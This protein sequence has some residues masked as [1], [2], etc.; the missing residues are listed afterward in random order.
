MEDQI[1]V[2]TVENDETPEVEEIESENSHDEE[3]IEEIDES[4]SE[5]SE[6][7]SDESDEDEEPKVKK[8]NGFKKRIDKLKH[9]EALAKEEADYWKQKALEKEEVKKEPSNTVKTNDAPDPDDFETYEDFVDALTDYKVEQKLAARSEAKSKETQQSKA[10]EQAKVWSEKVNSFSEQTP[11]F[12]EVMEDA[13]DFRISEAAKEALTFSESGPELMYLLA[14]NPEELERINSLPPAM[15][16]M[17]L[18]R[19]EAGLSKKEIKKPKTSKAPAP[20]S[21]LKGGAKVKKD[22]SDPNLSQREYEELRNE[23]LKKRA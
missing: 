14:K 19:M 3:A 9:R 21:R 13:A 2:T 5:E 4:S 1:E 6:E 23:Q 15:A 10:Q 8:K 11:D 12:E 22:L 17:A 7:E 18:G 20:I 16:V